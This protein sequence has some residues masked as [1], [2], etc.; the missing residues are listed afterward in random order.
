MM[1]TLLKG[2][3]AWAIHYVVAEGMVRNGQMRVIFKRL[4]T[5]LFLF[6][7]AAA[8]TWIG[9]LALLG[10]LFFYLAEIS[11]FVWPALIIGLIALV[12]A[13]GFLFE[14]FRLIRR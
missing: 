5:S 6:A 12:A 11:N 4:V 2:L 13:L 9:F 1:R 8:L 7:L 14:G 10:G 3:G